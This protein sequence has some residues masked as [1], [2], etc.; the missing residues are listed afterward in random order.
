MTQKTPTKKE[1][2]KQPVAQKE[3]TT[4]QKS[5]PEK[6]IPKPEEAKVEGTPKPEEVQPTPVEPKLSDI[7]LILDTLTA[8]VLDHAR[9]IGELQEAL[10]RKRKAVPN[11]KVQIR[12]KKTGKVYPSKNNTYQSL[13]KAGEL[14]D[15][16][17]AGVF[18]DNPVKNSFGWYA[19]VRE[20]P[21]RFAEVKAEEKTEESK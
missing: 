12:D 21:D 20:C 17:D 9:Q 5:Q 6:G 13:L 14:K 8:T 4:V 10:A 18:G 1:K 3:T 2:P 19:L 16:V 11:S 15:L 7:K